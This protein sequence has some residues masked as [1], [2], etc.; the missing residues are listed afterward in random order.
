[1]SMPIEDEFYFHFAE[2]KGLTTPPKGPIPPDDPVHPRL[3]KI[4]TMCSSENV[5]RDVVTRL[6]FIT[7]KNLKHPHVKALQTSPSCFLAWA[8]NRR[9]KLKLH[10][11]RC[12]LNT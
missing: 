1:M 11:R 5:A 6:P 4:R 10:T 2:N 8:F 12:M 3:I 7:M 9:V